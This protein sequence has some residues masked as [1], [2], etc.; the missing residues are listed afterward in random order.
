MVVSSDVIM[1]NYHCDVIIARYGNLSGST[2]LI[3]SG[4]SA[5]LMVK[6]QCPYCVC[7]LYT[8]VVFLECGLHDAID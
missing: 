6:E 4:F 2:F 3:S 7:T 1:S 5:M 8:P